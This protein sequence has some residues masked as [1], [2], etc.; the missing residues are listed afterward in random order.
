MVTKLPR[1][2]EKIGA[3]FIL[4]GKEGL[5]MFEHVVTQVIDMSSR[6]NTVTLIAHKSEARFV[7]E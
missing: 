7:L 4:G 6:R 3:N 2:A 1:P 5:N